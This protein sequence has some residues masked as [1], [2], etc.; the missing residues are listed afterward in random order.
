M[1]VTVAAASSSPETLPASPGPGGPVPL[2]LV[3]SMSTEKARVSP[4]PKSVNVALR[5]SKPPSWRPP[6]LC[7]M[8]PTPGLLS[9][10]KPLPRVSPPVPLGSNTRSGSKLVDRS[11]R[12]RAIFCAPGDALVTRNDPLVNVLEFKVGA[13]IAIDVDGAGPPAPAGWTSRKSHVAGNAGAGPA[14]V[15]M[16]PTAGAVAPLNH[17]VCTATGPPT[18]T[19]APPS[20]E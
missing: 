3:G 5:T 18:A 6:K 12:T 11:N 19:G 1:T 7:A 16:M 9:T 15:E 8:A 10:V 14:E 13:P 2:M 20:I 17:D 4:G